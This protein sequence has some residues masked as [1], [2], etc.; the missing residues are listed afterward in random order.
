MNFYKRHIGDYLKD[1]AH[2]SLLEHGVYSRL[3]DV[4]YTREAGIPD[5]Q[6]ARL[7][8]ARQRDEVAAL[9]IVLG[10]FFKL[11]DG[12]WIQDRCE[13]EIHA[14]G[15]KPEEG[16]DSPKS[17]KAERQKRYRERRK[18]M[19]D[20]LGSLGVTMPFD[21]SMDDLQD[22]LLRATATQNV[23]QNASRVTPTV[24]HETHNVTATNS[25]TP[26]SRLQT[27]DL[28]PK[29]VSPGGDIG[30]SAPANSDAP[31]AAA[32]ISKSII[33]WERERHKAARG[34]SASNVQVIELEDMCLSPGE[35][36][37]A[38]DMAVADREATGDP[39][40]VNAGFVKTFV[41]KVRNPPKPRPKADDWHRTDEGTDRKAAELKMQARAGESYPALRERIWAELRRREQQG[42]AA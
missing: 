34:V 16:D 37:K 25:Q 9:K 14:T 4:Y 28:K 19:F 12:T 38:Y 6:A 33:G 24:T 18:A 11:V 35:L 7:I 40:P 27:P 32:E 5:D 30:A 36:R 21:A 8:G 42:V 39:S 31:L 15:T 23:T 20:R 1:T 10:E 3:L 26:D 17:G 22:A 2:L 41:L 13:R 29:P